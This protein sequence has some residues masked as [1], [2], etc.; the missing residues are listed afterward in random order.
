[1]TVAERV[2]IEKELSEELEK[3][4]GHWVAVRGSEVIASS[5][6]P[7]KLLALVKDGRAERIFRVSSSAGAT[8]L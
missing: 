2:K 8:L 3:Y 7:K 5:E 4:A 6:R 1:M